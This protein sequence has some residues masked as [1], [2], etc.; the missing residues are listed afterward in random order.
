MLTSRSKLIFQEMGNTFPVLLFTFRLLPFHSLAGVD[1]CK[2]A[3]YTAPMRVMDLE[4]SRDQSGI[5]SKEA[6]TWLCLRD[7]IS[8]L[9]QDR[10]LIESESHLII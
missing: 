7:R 3:A 2:A 8:S 9:S 5:Q 6:A 4:A 10:T 1:R